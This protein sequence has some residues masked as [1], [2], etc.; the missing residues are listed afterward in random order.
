LRS[1]AHPGDAHKKTAPKGAVSLIQPWLV[2]SPLTGFE[3]ALRFVDHIN[4]AFAT[5]N[6]AITMPV[7]ERAERVLDLHGPSPVPVGAGQRLSVAGAPEIRNS[8]FMVGTTRFELVTP[9]MSTKCST[10]ELSAHECLCESNAPMK[11]GA[12]TRAGGAVYKRLRTGDQGLLATEL[13]GL[14]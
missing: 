6:A 12:E 7:L 11:R 2:R 4:A 13:S 14:W 5:H 9:S 10:T 1:T 3:P 8:E